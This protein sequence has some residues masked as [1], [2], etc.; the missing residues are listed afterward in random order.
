VPIYVGRGRAR[1][2]LALNARR[3]SLTLPGLAAVRKTPG[4]SPMRMR[5]EKRAATRATPLIPPRAGL[6]PTRIGI[7]S[8]IEVKRAAI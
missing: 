7:P 6:L 4:S 8:H 3:A 1:A 5:R 2:T